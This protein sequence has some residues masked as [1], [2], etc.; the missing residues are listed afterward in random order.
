MRAGAGGVGNEEA[1]V[2][3]GVHGGTAVNEVVIGWRERESNTIQR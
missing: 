3:G 1:I 2:Y